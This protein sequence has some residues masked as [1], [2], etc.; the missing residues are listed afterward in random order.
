MIRSMLLSIKHIKQD[1][2]DQDYYINNLIEFIE[3]ELKDNKQHLIYK[4]EE[5]ERDLELLE[6]I[7]EKI[8]EKGE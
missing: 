2:E 4:L 7:K 1:K 6:I 3:S 8:K 5:V